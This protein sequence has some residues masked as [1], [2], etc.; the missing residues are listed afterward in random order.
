MRH[1]STA[2]LIAPALATAL[3]YGLTPAAAAT[4]RLGGGS[5]LDVSLGRIFAALTISV[6]VAVLAILL[7]RQ[8][9]GKTDL[10]ALFSRFEIRPS[11]VEIVETRRMSMHAEISVIRHA[12]REYLLL[13]MAGNA[14]VLSDRPIGSRDSTPCD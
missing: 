2:L 5:A 9:A 11:I 4:G 3:L 8:R 7:V 1:A 12:G 6:V 13:L 14:Q 10:R